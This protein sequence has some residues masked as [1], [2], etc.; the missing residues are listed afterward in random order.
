[1][2]LKKNFFFFWPNNVACRVLVLQPRIKPVPP[3]SG[4][5]NLNHWGSAGNCSFNKPAST[6]RASLLAQI[7]KSLP[8]IQ[9]TWVQFLI[10]EDPLEKGMATHSSILAWEIPWTEEPRWLQSMGSQR[11]TSTHSPSPHH[12]SS[13]RCQQVRSLNE[14]SVPWMAC[15]AIYL[16]LEQTH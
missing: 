6:H 3:A 5:W 14:R 4:A 15:P 13:S 12:P 8:A 10:W 11:V 16:R 1:M 2:L 9:E 7:V